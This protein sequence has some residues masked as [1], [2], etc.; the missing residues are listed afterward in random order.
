MTQE[1]IELIQ[2][3]IKSI[4]DYPKPGILFRDVTSLMENPDAYR[5]TMEVLTER[6]KDKGITK[7]IGTEARGF[8]FGA[9]LALALGVGFVPVRKPGKLP[10]EVIAESYE[11][12]YGKDTLEIHLD[13][14]AEGDKVLLVDDLLATGG[15]IEATTNLVRRLGGVVE[16]A[17]FVI[18]LPDIGGEERL[19]GLGL[20]VYSICDF[21]GH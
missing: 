11:L 10:R 12:E 7:I 18:N 17:A 4:Q 16:D 6:Y 14:I 21:P 1:K 5:A 2:S 19:K 13:A 20:N 3:S 15:T 8:L 9:P